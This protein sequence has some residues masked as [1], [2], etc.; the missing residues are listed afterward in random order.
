MSKTTISVILLLLFGFLEFAFAQANFSTSLHSTRNGKPFWYD[1]SNGGFET[2]TGVPIDGL[3]CVQCHGATD[4]DGNS[5]PTD[6]T[7]ACIDC[8][9]TGTTTTSQARC[10][11]CH[12]REG[13]IINLGISDV[14]RTAGFTCMSCH[15]SNDVHGNGTEYNSMFE[16]GAIAADCS[17]T[18]CHGG[19]DPHANLSSNP[20]PHNGKIHCAS[21]HASTNL[22]CYNC[23]FE[24]Q[25]ETHLKRAQRQITGFII[26]VNR[27]KDNKVHPATFQS[28]S[29]QGKTWIAMGPSVAHT[30]TRDNARIC[31]DCHE[32]FGGSIPAITEYNTDG[33][34]KFATWNSSDS[35]LSWMQGIVPLPLD[36]LRSF[37]LDYITY[38]GSTSDP[39]APSKNWSFVSDHSDGFQLLA[40]T[41]L[42]KYQMAKLGIDT[43]K[44]VLDVQLENSQIP[45]DYSLEQN[46]PNPFNPN[47]I[48]KYSV[49]NAGFVEINVYDALG[50]LV[51]QLIGEQHQAGNYKVEFDGTGLT[52]GVYFYQIKAGNFTE[53]KK[54]I[55]MK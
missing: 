52:S 4:A 31:T 43:N 36:Y 19:S 38:D 6:Y 2:L 55:L 8:H 1:A 30:I 44:V 45:S 26:L 20:D 23:H 3:G 46:F 48:I 32:N 18:G 15:T 14:H 13:A 54:L 47:T 33:T 34:M 22:A 16:S 41:P 12:S 39:V 49:P 50:K 37:K 42:S 40:A 10:L 21:C 29:Y 35:T 28:V 11:S 24:S 53:T 7:P 17:N 25:V 27:T 5:Y 51:K 9:A